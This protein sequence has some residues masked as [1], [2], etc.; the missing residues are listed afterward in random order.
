MG[1][2]RRRP[3]R[4]IVKRPAR[5]ADNKA[6]VVSVSARTIG[7]NRSRVEEHPIDLGSGAA[8]VVDLAGLISAI[9]IAEVAAFEDR[10]RDGELLAFL[11][12]EQLREAAG[13]GSVRF[14]QWST[15]GPPPTPVDPDEAVATALLAFEDGLFKVVLDG[16]DVPELSTAV[17]VGDGA[18]VMF[19][20]LVALAGG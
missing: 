5:A 13:R 3:A 2:R 8:G 10:R 1:R 19:V 9:V 18:T 16:V 6:M 7:R 20:R 17:S 11:S 4:S 15:D 14:T 12:D